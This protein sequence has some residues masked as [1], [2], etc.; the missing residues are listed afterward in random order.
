MRKDINLE[1][2]PTNLLQINV[3]IQII[4]LIRNLCTT[5][6]S[7]SGKF[8]GSFDCKIRSEEVTFILVGVWLISQILLHSSALHFV[9][10]TFITSSIK[11][12]IMQH[13]NQF[14]Q[15]NVT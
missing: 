9:Y 2:P 5:N 8:S 10:Q 1:I 12:Q 4:V 7:Q 14:E 15:T 11:W 6:F 3:L 13:V